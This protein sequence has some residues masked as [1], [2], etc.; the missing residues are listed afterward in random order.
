VYAYPHK[1]AYRKL[2]PPVPLDEIWENEQTDS[3][4]LYVHVP[5]CEM[6]CGF[7]NLF[8]YSQPG[9]SLPDRFLQSLR[10]QAQTV[11]DQIGK[12][13]ISRMAV[14]GGTPTH[15]S[16]AQLEHL[17]ETVS[18]FEIDSHLTPLSFEASPTTID[19]ESWL[20]SRRS[21]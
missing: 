12:P 8:T 18:V 9:E 5:F 13:G 10:G 21:A 17:F 4:F 2:T 3:L 15:L 19:R 20:N 11:H 6:R 16:A 1:T 14:G 7:C